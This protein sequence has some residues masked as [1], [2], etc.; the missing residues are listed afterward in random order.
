MKNLTFFGML[1]ALFGISV[2]QAQDTVHRYHAPI[3]L[4]QPRIERDWLFSFDLQSGGGHTR[5]ARNSFRQIVPLF[6]L[7]GTSNIQSLGRSVDPNSTDPNNRLLRDLA[8]LPTRVSFGHFSINGLFDYTE[9]TLSA[10]QNLTHGFF[11]R[12][13]LPI[14]NFEIRDMQFVDV[15]PDDTIFPNRNT[16]EWQA[17]TQNFDRILDSYQLDRGNIHEFGAGD[18]TL[19][20]GWTHNYQETKH[21]DFIDITLQGGILLPTGKKKNPDKIFSLPLGYNG[22]VGF[23]FGLELSIGAYDWLTLGCAVQGIAF[24]PRTGFIRLHTSLDDQGMIALFKDRASMH[25]GSIWQTGF[26]ITADHFS[27]GFSLTGGYSFSCERPTRVYPEDFMR[28]DRRA[29]RDMGQLRGFVMHNLHINAEYDFTQQN[30]RLGPRV[31]L[32]WNKQL[33]GR[34]T[35]N[36]GYTAGTFGLEIIV[37]Y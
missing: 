3:F 2:L 29:L 35:F 16:P 37:T 15:S 34:R 5:H 7:F 17:V 12:A 1:I 25:R 14:R 22:H 11:V 20:C 13:F 10:I 33:R 30:W 23:P 32:S 24:I 6:D 19:G 8:T 18:L 31:G 4:A 26:F 9:T 21:L 27:R 36:T 28:F